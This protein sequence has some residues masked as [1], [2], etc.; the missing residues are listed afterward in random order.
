M[1]GVTLLGY[2]TWGGLL[3][4]AGEKV[5]SFHHII[6]D[7]P[8]SY[9]EIQIKLSS[10]TVK[11][12]VTLSIRVALLLFHRTQITWSFQQDFG[13]LMWQFVS[14]IFS[15]VFMRSGSDVGWEGP[16][17]QSPVPVP[18]KGA[19]VLELSSGFWPPTDQERSVIHH[20]TE[21]FPLL[22]IP[23]SACFTTSHSTTLDLAIGGL[24]GAARLFH[25]APATVFILLSKWSLWTPQQWNQQ[26]AC[27]FYEPCIL[28]PTL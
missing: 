28:D 10:V 8:Y 27:D 5:T 21:P 13:V 11:R 9:Y 24:R 15:G 18:P 7:S 12:N 1:A 20:S 25:E 22:H 16:G 26:R 17:S 4:A 6:Q 19:P 3:R 23:A 2:G 14:V